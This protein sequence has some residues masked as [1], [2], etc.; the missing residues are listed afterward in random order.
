MLWV[1]SKALKLL[2]VA[3]SFQSDNDIVSVCISK[4]QTLPNR[5]VCVAVESWKMCRE[6]TNR[7]T[8]SLSCVDPQRL[9]TQGCWILAAAVSSW[10]AWHR[11]TRLTF[12]ASS[13]RETPCWTQNWSGKLICYI[14]YNVYIY[15]QGNNSILSFIVFEWYCIVMRWRYLQYIYID[16]YIYIYIYIL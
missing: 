14:S 2:R 10:L 16:I 9:H 5:C 15:R 4:W 11:H 12:W 8:F 6:K 3:L 1:D 7:H 13:H